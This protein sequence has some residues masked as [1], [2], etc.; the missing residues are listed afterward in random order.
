MQDLNIF[1]RLTA[2]DLFCGCGGISV[3]LQSAGFNVLAGVDI[4]K[5]YIC[6]FTKNFPRAKTITE[7]ITCIP[8]NEFLDK[9]ELKKGELT[10]LAGGPPCQGFSKNVPRKHRFLEDD[11]N[12]LIR[13]FLNYCEGLQPKMILMENVAE[14][15]N[16]FN[17]AYTQEIEQRLNDAGYTVHHAVLTAADYGVPQRRRRAFFM[18]TRLGFSFETPPRTHMPIETE[19]SRGLFEDQHYVS[20]WEAIGDLPSLSHGEMPKV[21]KYAESPQNQFQARMRGEKREVTNHVARKLAPTQFARLSSLEPGQGLKDLPPELQTKGGFSGAYGRLTK[22][23]VAPTITRWVFH[24]GSGRWGHPVDI[25]TLSIREIARIQS[26]PDSYEFEGS[27]TDQAGQLGNAVPPLLAE[28]VAAFML[29]EAKKRLASGSCSRNLKVKI[30]EI[31]E[32]A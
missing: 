8:P 11:R 20:V 28:V 9:I 21:V 30:P 31:P 13:T 24:P 32:S 1:D 4:N 14:M 18:A 7:D 3:G 16:G 5:K 25:R 26:F 19:Q 23:M 27:F 22:S 29:A 10:L 12:Q 17:Q 6:S 15:R 2:V